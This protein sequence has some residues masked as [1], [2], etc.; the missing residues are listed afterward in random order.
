MKLLARYVFDI[1]PECINIPNYQLGAESHRRKIGALKLQFVLDNKSGHISYAF[2]MPSPEKNG[3]HDIMLTGGGAFQ[4]Y[5]DGRKPIYKH[6]NALLF[7]V[8]FA[9]DTF[10]FG[11]KTETIYY[12]NQSLAFIETPFFTLERFVHLRRRILRGEKFER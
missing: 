11:V 3:Y 9:Y 1:T 4:K 7:G 10:N 8:D 6:Y 5:V 12:I 2:W